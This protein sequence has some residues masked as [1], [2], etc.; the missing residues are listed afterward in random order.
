MYGNQ[1]V[2]AAK[3]KRYMQK[4]DPI[5]I[6]KICKKKDPGTNKRKCATK[7]DCRKNKNVYAKKK[8]FH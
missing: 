1:K 6:L 7:R 4:N 3:I 2:I 5:K 8:L